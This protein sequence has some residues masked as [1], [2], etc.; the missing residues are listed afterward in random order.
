MR[1]VVI[2]GR[3]RGKVFDLGPGRYLVGRGDEADIQ[4]CDIAASRRHCLIE[5]NAQGRVRVRDLKSAN[6]TFVDG[7][8][9]RTAP[10]RD[11][12]VLRVGES[13]L[14]LAVEPEKQPTTV[15][16][17][18]RGET[19]MTE[20]MSALIFCAR[21]NESIPTA[22]VEEGRAAVIDGEYYCARCLRESGGNHHAGNSTHPAGS[23]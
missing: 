23:A 7:K 13:E 12:S 1:L 6:G 5:I 8:E 16:T 10:L 2:S 19:D 11:G 17:A 22:E 3:Q 15:V 20:F 21:C 14:T 18:A 4:V 9:V